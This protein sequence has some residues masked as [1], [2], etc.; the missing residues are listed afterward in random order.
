[1]NQTAETHK[2]D[3][4]HSPD[5]SKSRRFEN[6]GAAKKELQTAFNDWSSILT[7]H[8]RQI[9]FAIIAANWA[10][11]GDTSKV[12]SNWGAKWS[13]AIVFIFLGVDLLITRLLIRQ[14][15]KQYLYA[16]ENEKRWDDEYIEG[17][18]KRYWPYTALIEYTGIFY[19]EFK[20]WAPMFAAILFV[21]SLFSDR[22]VIMLLVNRLYNFILLVVQC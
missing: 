3:E 13:M 15:Y 6:A 12:I 16:E 7:E 1:M 2:S 8:S 18:E 14:H 20:C 9:A 11:H 21:V 19:R 5:R 4:F 17:R 10:V 22:D